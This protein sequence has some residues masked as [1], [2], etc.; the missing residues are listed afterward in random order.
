M[1]RLLFTL[2]LLIFGGCSF[3]IEVLNN[4]PVNAR[5]YYNAE[6]NKWSDYKSKEAIQ[7]VKHTTTGKNVY[8]EFVADGLGY[9]VNST[10]E[11][12]YNGDLIGYNKNTLKFHRIFF[13]DGNIVEE[14]LNEK[15]ISEIFPECEIVKVSEFKNNYIKLKRSPFKKKTYL[16]MNDTNLMFYN[17]RFENLD[18]SKEPCSNIFTPSK[19]GRYIFAPTEKS[20]TY[21][22]YTIH[23]RYVL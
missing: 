11:F 15:E 22:P 21:T 2:M 5:L 4:I 9:D 3:A 1:Y 14:R 23:V 18:N 10:Q 16:L 17:Y 20:V 12:F 19:F 7:F 8:S 6:T 13:K